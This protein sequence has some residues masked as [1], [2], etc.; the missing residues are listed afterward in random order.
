MASGVTADG[1]EPELAAIRARASTVRDE[2][3]ERALRR[4][5]A[6]GE[7]TPERRE[8]IERLADRLVDRLVAVPEAGI[9]AAEGDEV[10]ETALA[11]FGE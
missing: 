9:A 1:D 6:R 10:A 7:L 4:L 11:L 3:V 2:Q 8:A 5:E